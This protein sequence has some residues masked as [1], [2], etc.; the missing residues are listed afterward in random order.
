MERMRQRQ[1]WAVALLSAVTTVAI[2][3][4][5]KWPQWRGPLNTGMAHGDAP[6]EW[7]DRS[8]I[9]WKLA[10]PGR[11]HST[12]VVAGKLL[13]LTAA[14]PTGKGTPL[15]GGRAGGGADAGLE[16]R[17]EVIAVDRDTGAI[18]WRR[19]ATVATPH[20]GYHRVYGSFASNS[21]VTDGTRVFA[22]FG[23]R[24][25]YAYDVEGTLLW[26]KDFGVKM[27]MDLAFG[28]GTPLTLHDNRL[29]L[30]FDHLDTGFL[31]MLDP[32]SGREIWHV[33]R[34]ERYNWAAPYVARHDGRRQIIVS[35]E[36]VRG[37]D[38]D[39]GALLW[40]AAGLGENSIPQPVQHNDLVFAMSGHTIKMLMAIRL[41]RGGNLT[42]TGAIAWSTARG[43][44]YTP[45]PLLHEG[46]LY[47]ITDSG[48]LS[49]FDAATGKALYQQA[50]LPKP[51][52]FKASPVGAAGKLF[53]ATEEG[54]VVVVRMGDRF[55]VLATNTLTDQSFIA[56]PVIVEGD[57]YL[58][59]RTHL[60][61]VSARSAERLN[62]EE[63]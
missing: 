33:K 11:G 13:F 25:L 61:K 60:F 9:A 63:G 58:R 26:R 40:E 28:E 31:V 3:A 37:Y 53:L 48:Q 6:L 29:L 43:A 34:T 4:Q 19:T 22:F 8:N 23:S 42:G 15:G 20:E 49:C 46:R 24:G 47:V 54:D 27:R 38:F 36:T 1:I 30:H 2:G 17:F 51:Y 39:T 7:S 50:R 32:A 12:P 16:H 62:R 41:G 56:S 10:I 35:G 18:A 59:S 45:S 57:I 14:V 55:E 52:N 44:A 5:P 21:P